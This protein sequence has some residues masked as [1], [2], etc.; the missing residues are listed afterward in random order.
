M[1]EVHPRLRFV[2]V[3]DGP[4]RSGL[5]TAHPECIFTGFIPRDALACHYASADVYVHASLTE[6]FG[7]VLT[8]A[9]AS[10][11]A[12]AGFDYAAARQFVRHGENGL[13]VPCNTPEA[14]VASATELA[15]DASLRTRLRTAAAT[16]FTGQS[17]E[18]I[19]TRFEADLAAVIAATAR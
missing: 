10:G 17:W 5:Q 7:N 3:G 8:E 11:L 9:M 2:L 4:L 19:I 15:R 18:A 1:R 13:A 12:I 6:T 16:T 14:L